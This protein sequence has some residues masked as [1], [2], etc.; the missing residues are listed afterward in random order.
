MAVST[1]SS[2]N[3]KLAAPT[4][5]KPGG[6]SWAGGVVGVSES[7]VECEEGGT[8]KGYCQLVWI[9]ADGCAR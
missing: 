2:G 5:V 3:R 9:R 8:E 7:G 1:A 4:T 6:S